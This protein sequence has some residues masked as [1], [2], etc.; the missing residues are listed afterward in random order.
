MSKTSD[1]S[2]HTSIDVRNE[3][4]ILFGNPKDPEVATRINKAYLQGRKVELQARPSFD[5]GLGRCGKH[6]C[7]CKEICLEKYA[8]EQTV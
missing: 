3:T 7:H 4:L 2:K 6:L 8:K 5:T 1:A